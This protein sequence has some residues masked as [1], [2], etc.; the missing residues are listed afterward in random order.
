VAGKWLPV[1]HEELN[2]KAAKE[3]E[4]CISGV[5]RKVD[6][7]VGGAQGPAGPAGPEGPQGP[8]GDPGPQGPKGDTGDAGPAGAQGPQG[9]TGAD[10]AAGATG[11]TGPQGP[12]GPQGDPG[13]QGPQG[14]PGADGAAGAAGVGV[15]VG[16]T[17]GQ[18]LRKASNADHDTEWATPSPSQG[19]ASAAWP[20][21]SIFISAVDTNPSTLL[22]FGTWASF[23]AGRVLVGYDV[24][25][26]EFDA[27]NQTG[28]TKTHTLTE[29][30]IPSHTH[31]QDAHTHAVTDPGHVHVQGVNSTATGGLSGYTADTST[32]TR[33][34]SGYSTSSATT[35]ITLGNAT[36]TNQATGGGGAHNN[37]QPYV[38]VMFWR[39][40]A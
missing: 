14:N 16:G 25:Q 9:L 35:G 27:L 13:I 39:R 23:G 8:Q 1:C 6:A 36:A 4:N 33:V 20:I 31:V 40:T 19:D 32:N 17:Q 28:G 10:G 12:A 26:T 37:L 29:S 18:V 34:N 7:V 15:P 24:T 22:G 30:E 21:G 5:Y 3:L 38:T 2:P 11:S